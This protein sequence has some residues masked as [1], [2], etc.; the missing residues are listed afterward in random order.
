[1]YLTRAEKSLLFRKYRNEGLSSID[2]QVKLDKVC[3]YLRNL[4]L[5]LKRK[6]LTETNI[7]KKFRE[8]FEKLCMKY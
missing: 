2:S 3:E 1:M 6:N 4:I 8:E 7:N 5:E